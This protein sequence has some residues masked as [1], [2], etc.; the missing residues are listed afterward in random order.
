MFT[1]SCLTSS[2]GNTSH[3]EP[4]GCI[5]DSF[6]SL[7]LSL[8]QRWEGVF[9][10]CVPP[11]TGPTLLLLACSVME[12]HNSTAIMGTTPAVLEER[13]QKEETI[14]FPLHTGATGK[15]GN[16]SE[17]PEGYSI[18]ELWGWMVHGKRASPPKA[19]S[20]ASPWHWLAK[21][22]QGEAAAEQTSVN[23]S[24]FD[25]E[26]D[27]SSVEWRWSVTLG[28]KKDASEGSRTPSPD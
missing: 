2:S 1:S 17:T 4:S 28:T 22:L 12:T 10:L 7:F 8:K 16:N 5:A 24:H 20:G 15:A 19:H 23:K 6:L 13:L 3:E 9:I 27:K 26:S 21:F 18:L 11:G 14:P 25:S